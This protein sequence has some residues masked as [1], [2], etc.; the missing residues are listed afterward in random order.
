[1]R[2]LTPPGRGAIAV[3]AVDTTAETAALLAQLQF[4]GPPPRAGDRREVATLRRC[5]LSLPDGIVDDALLIALGGGRCE[6]HVHGSP[7]VVEALRRSFGPFAAAPVSPAEQLLQQ[8]LSPPQLRL[9]MEQRRVDFEAWLRQLAALPDEARRR[10]LAA[11]RQRSQAALALAVPQR[12]VLR[13][14]QNAGKST[15]MNRLLFRERVLVGPEP[16]L[17]R[18]AVH[19]LTSLAGYPYE[20]VD[21][22][23]E[24][25]AGTAIDRAAMHR[26]A[27]LRQ[28]ALVLLL[29]DGSRGPDAWD[30]AQLDD[31]TMVLATK[32]DLPQAE[33]PAQVPCA[34]RIACSTA[35]AAAT[36]RRDLGECLR[37]WRRLPPAGPVGGP[38]ALTAAQRDEL[39]RLT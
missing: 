21:T 23:G 5:R 16:G 13:G 24:G 11:A 28:Q 34:L 1:M 8:A 9:A 20:L 36:L 18:D 39:E 22:A 30:R 26:A 17:T 29:I 32:A 14:R 3:L 2:L 27:E 19:E 4:D 33:W 35:A 12:L 15:L 25:P 7:A 31:A 6:L 38:A 10:Q 37:Q